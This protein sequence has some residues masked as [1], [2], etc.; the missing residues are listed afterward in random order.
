MSQKLILNVEKKILICSEKAE[1]DGKEGTAV[2]RKFVDS[3]TIIFQSCNGIGG[4]IMNL[5]D[6]LTGVMKQTQHLMAS[7]KIK[8]SIS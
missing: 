4:N 3:N 8:W 1:N 6:R 2:C 5:N 7:Y